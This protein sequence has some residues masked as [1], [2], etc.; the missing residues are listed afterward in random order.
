N[1]T[2]TPHRQSRPRT[3]RLKHELRRLAL[4]WWFLQAGAR[5]SKQSRAR[6]EAVA[7]CI[8]CLLISALCPPTSAPA[9]TITGT[10][11]NTSGGSYPTNVLFAP[12]STP[13]ASGNNTIASTPTNIL[14]APN[15]TFSV[16]LKQG[17]YLATIGNL[18]RDS[19]LISVPNDANTYNIN[20]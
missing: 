11:I 3:A 9:S 7:L 19:L 16:T 5:P 20:S 10:V 17:N 15:G 6:K 1:S 2:Q 18:R 8:F 14:T 13:L 12:L 4:R